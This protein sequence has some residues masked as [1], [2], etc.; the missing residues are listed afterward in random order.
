MRASQKLY[1]PLSSEI[2]TDNHI[3]M[4]IRKSSMFAAHYLGGNTTEDDRI[5][6]RI[7]KRFARAEER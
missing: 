5:E 3:V 4:S 7:R 6:E 1:K 2:F